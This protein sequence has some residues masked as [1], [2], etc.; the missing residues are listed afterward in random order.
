MD[1]FDQ[2]NRQIVFQYQRE[3]ANF[4]Q[5]AFCRSHVDRRNLQ[6]G[7]RQLKRS[8][9]SLIGANQGLPG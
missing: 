2:A 1:R 3:L 4:I 7:Q 6:V 5:T 9:N 8:R